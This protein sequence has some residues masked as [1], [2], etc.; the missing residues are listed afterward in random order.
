MLNISNRPYS[1]HH[2][3]PHC[4]L[5]LTAMS[6]HDENFL[7]ELISNWDPALV[8]APKPEPVKQ[9]A[10]QFCTYISH[11]GNRCNKRCTID[12]RCW[13]H[14]ASVSCA[15]CPV[16]GCTRWYRTNNLFPMCSPHSTSNRTAANNRKMLEQKREWRQQALK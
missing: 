10:Q 6:S 13:I 1:S 15:P 3:A 7:A 14:H 2:R 5:H 12:E 16:D 11:S 4:A 9:A 8:L